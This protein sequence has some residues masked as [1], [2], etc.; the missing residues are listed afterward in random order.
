EAVPRDDVARER[1]TR[2]RVD[3]R[4]DAAVG[5]PRIREVAVAFGGRRQVG[6]DWHGRPH[7][8]REL[9]RQEEIHLLLVRAT[10]DEFRD[11]DRAADAVPV[12][13][14]LEVRLRRTGLLTQVVVRVPV[15]APR[16]VPARA[17]QLVGARLGDDLNQ[18]ARLPAVLRGV[19]AR[20]DRD[21]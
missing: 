7:V 3:D 11:D 6:P 10:V 4:L 15:L 5:E 1:L 20:D 19:A 17:L 2:Q 21:L 13:V 14:Y 8:V 18:A 12:D 16:V 9:L